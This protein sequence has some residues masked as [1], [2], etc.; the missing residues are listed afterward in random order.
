MRFAARGE[1]AG[2]GIEADLADLDAGRRSPAC[3]RSSMRT[4]AS[5]SE[6]SKGLVM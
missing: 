2:I 3:R 6:T 1:G 4:R 5:S